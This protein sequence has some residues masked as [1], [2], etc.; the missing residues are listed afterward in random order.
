MTHTR[1]PSGANEGFYQGQR[2]SRKEE[3]F[4]A[5]KSQTTTPDWNEVQQN[6]QT[7]FSA[8]QGDAMVSV[9]EDL[10]RDDRRLGGTGREHLAPQTVQLEASAATP[11][12]AV[13]SQTGQITLDDIGGLSDTIGQPRSTPEPAPVSTPQSAK[14][15]ATVER[16]YRSPERDKNIQGYAVN[17]ETA[18]KAVQGEMELDID[19]PNDQ[20]DRDLRGLKDQIPDQLHTQFD[21]AI[22]A[23]VEGDLNSVNEGAQNILRDQMP[24]SIEIDELE[25]T[26]KVNLENIINDTS[27]GDTK[28]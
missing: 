21:M 16:G 9:V 11:A 1:S 2:K 23:A 3:G 12:S 14:E 13:G 27:S 24:D 19:V 6:P 17:T 15:S 4:D 26:N 8:N 20:I 22:E 10:V 18:T 28:N 7:G 25:G 5:S